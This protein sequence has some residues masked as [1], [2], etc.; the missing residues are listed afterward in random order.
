MRRFLSLSLLIF[1]IFILN[2]Q[3]LFSSSCK[4]PEKGLPGPTG[5]TGPT[6]LTGPTGPTGSTGPA[7]IGTFASLTLR[8]SQVVNPGNAVVFTDVD[9]L[10]GN[11]SY[12]LITGNITINNPGYYMVTYGVTATATNRQFILRLNGL[13]VAGSFFDSDTS[14]MEGI[15]L[16]FQTTIPMSNLQAINNSGAATTLQANTAT[17]ETAYITILQIE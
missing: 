8:G 9:T 2:I 11:L 5:A 6:G 7:S 1:A 4:M 12:D 13:D 3:P 16:I 14:V 17:S 15:S 10:H